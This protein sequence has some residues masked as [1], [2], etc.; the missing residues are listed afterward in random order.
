MVRKVAPAPIAFAALL[1]A[2]CSMGWMPDWVGG[3]DKPAPAET[4]AAG[5]SNEFVITLPADRD[6]APEA[7]RYCGQSDRYAR[8]AD[9]TRMPGADPGKDTITWTFEC[10]F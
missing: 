9:A 10:L 6:P 1:L 4:A 3:G 2:G 7:T 5:K 8:L